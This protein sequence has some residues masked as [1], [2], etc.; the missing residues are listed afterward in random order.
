MMALQGDLNLQSHSLGMMTFES[1]EDTSGLPP[2]LMPI[3]GTRAAARRRY[4]A[5]ATSPRSRR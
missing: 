2:G 4:C 1:S 3:Q 5:R